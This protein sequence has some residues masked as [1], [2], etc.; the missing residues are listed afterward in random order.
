M[1]SGTPKGHHVLMRVRQRTVVAWVAALSVAAAGGAVALAAVGDDAAHRLIH[2]HVLAGATAA[3][4]FSVIGAAVVRRLPSNRVGWL[5][6]GIGASQALSGLVTEYGYRA[7]ME[8]PAG[9][10][11]GAAVA[12]LDAW[13]WVPSFVAIITLLV[14]WFPDGQIHRRWVRVPLAIAG[15]GLVGFV[16]PTAVMAWRVRG[17]VIFT[18]DRIDDG[19][20]LAGIAD[21]ALLLVLV[22][23]AGCVVA[24]LDR[25][26]RATGRERQ[27]LLWFAAGAVLCVGSLIVAGPDSSIGPVAELVAL[28]L[29]PAAIGLALLRYR[30][31]DMEFVVNRVLLYAGLTMVTGLLYVSAVALFTNVLDVGSLAG[32]VL[33]SGVVAVGFD[34]VRRTLERFA[35]RRLFGNRHNPAAAMVEVTRSVSSASAPDALDAIATALVETLRLRA[36]RVTLHSAEGVELVGAVGLVHAVT[37]SVPLTFD[38][39]DLGRLDVEAAPGMSIDSAARRLLDDLAAQ[40]AIAAHAILLTTELRRSRAR[41]IEAVEQERRRLRR[42]LHDGLGTAL[43]GIVMQLEALSNL[44]DGQSAASDLTQTIT[45]EARQLVGETRRLVHGL[46]PPVVEEVG[47]VEALRQ[48][49]DR[50]NRTGGRRGT[51]TVDTDG[52]VPDRL[53]AAVEV[54]AYVIVTEAMTNVARH[55]RATRCQVRLRRDTQLTVEVV[56]DG[57]G[58]TGL[59]HEGVGLRSM[60]ERTEDLDGVL[61]VEPLR[62]RGTRVVASLPL[63][64]H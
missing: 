55:A 31:Y 47:L 6:V 43:V 53:P 12:S 40:I 51:F 2:G 35:D 8:R 16:V 46:V 56:D 21:V 54:A 50:L 14:A 41:L 15:L 28:P 36:A 23:A 4:A 19:S 44:L 33:A 42:D 34:R 52:W 37:A 18:A 24:A 60:R 45:T 61:V 29:L 5:C 30:L 57:V 63:E 38:D 9:M 39:R 62:D 26:R 3:L 10:P 48:H 1:T 7:V 25:L 13:L 22:G 17:P 20:A 27:Q 59:S 32:A 64:V 49:A 58:L 11:G